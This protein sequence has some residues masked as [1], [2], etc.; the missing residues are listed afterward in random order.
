MKVYV[1]RPQLSSLGT[2]RV[3]E[4]ILNSSAQTKAILAS[5]ER[6]KWS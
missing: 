3:S 1:E 2:G 6:L 5:L 4:T